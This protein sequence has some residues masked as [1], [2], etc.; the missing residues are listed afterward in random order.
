VN[1]EHTEVSPR[2]PEGGP[3]ASIHDWWVAVTGRVTI[4]LD[5]VGTE[6][7]LALRSIAVAIFLSVIAALI[8]VVGW[9]AAVTGL[10]VVAVGNG[11]SWVS[12]LAVASAVH[13][14]GAWLLLRKAGQL[15]DH[16]NFETTRA[17]IMQTTGEESSSAQ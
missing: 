6:A 5:L 9:G 13:V 17:A 3:V 11:S 16:V 2:G 15:L 10:M 1:A 14:I 8:I 7:S 4:L 12:V